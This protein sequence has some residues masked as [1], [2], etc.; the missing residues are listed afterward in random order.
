MATA[1]GLTSQVQPEAAAPAEAAAG[2]GF[3]I[4]GRR[5]AA[6]ELKRL[7]SAGQD[8][9]RKTQALA[10][11]QRQLAAQQEALAAVV[12]YLQPELE[13]LQQQVQGA[14]PPPRELADTNPQ[15]YL[16]QLAAF[17]DAQREQQRLAQLSQLNAQAMN[18]AMARQVEQSNA[19][20]AAEFP[21]WADPDKRAEWQSRIAEWAVNKGGYTKD[22]L[23]GLVDHRHLKTM[24]KAM[25]FDKMLEG[26]RTAAP[27]Q[28]IQTVVRGSAPPPPASVQVRD[29]ETAFEQRPNVR[30]AA[31]LWGARKASAR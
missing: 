10:D 20:L 13:R 4:D 12:P 30:N 9:T 31:A 14:P 21:Q 25:Q 3:E 15:E 6:D 2:D 24:M 16:R 28:R 19:A 26:A 5:Y 8:Y 27:I 22:E 23:R 11:Q 18:N 17:Q 1:L 29:A 7:V